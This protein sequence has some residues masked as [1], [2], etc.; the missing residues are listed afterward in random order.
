MKENV[1][2]SKSYGFALQI[3]NLYKY[4]TTEKKEYVLSKQVLHA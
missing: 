3:V 2:K 4:V 1:L